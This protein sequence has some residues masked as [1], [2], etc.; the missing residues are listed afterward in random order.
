[1]IFAVV[2]MTGRDAVRG[3]SLIELLIVV[4]VIGIIAAI[5]VPNYRN[6]VKASNEAVAISYLRTWTAA[7]E[8]YFQRKG[9][10]ADADQQLIAEGLIGYP[11]P[12]RLGY[13]YS[14]DNPAGMTTQ[15]WGR[16]SPQN[17]G[18]S[19]D[20]YFFIDSTG[21]IRWSLGGPA[22]AASKP[23]GQP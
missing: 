3:F 7:Q 10:Y 23:L 15:W 20:R 9:V 5:A 22:T 17:P 21:V 2:T 4:A 14:I 13:R 8:L 11:N 1:M 16:A 19:G 6:S 18:V 12:D